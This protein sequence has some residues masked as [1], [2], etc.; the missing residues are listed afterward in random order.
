MLSTMLF[1]TFAA[2]IFAAQNY[3]QWTT[4][5]GVTTILSPNSL[6]IQFTPPGGS[7]ISSNVAQSAGTFCIS[8]QP[9]QV[10]GVVLSMRLTAGV[11]SHSQEV[12][13]IFYT[14]LLSQREVQ[15]NVWP[16]PN[17]NLITNN[18]ITVPNSISAY[19][20]LNWQEG[21]NV[22][23]YIDGT[24]EATASLA[25]FT[26]PLKP[27]IFTWGDQTSA[28]VLALSG[29]YTAGASAI[30]TY[31]ITNTY[32]SAIQEVGPTSLSLSPTAVPT[33]TTVPSNAPSA[34]PSSQPSFKPSKSPFVSTTT[35][36]YTQTIFSTNSQAPTGLTVSSN[37]DSGKNSN[38]GIIVGATVGLIVFM[39][40]AGY[41]VYHYYRMESKQYDH[42]SS[43]GIDEKVSFGVYPY[44]SDIEGQNNRYR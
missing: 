25:T 1:S 44:R 21:S 30:T 29:P 5:Y 20:C 19:Y 23:L 43:K 33:F 2:Q 39:L 40:I 27:Q 22:N 18:V 14:N 32:L 9:P 26:E 7:M 38:A 36:S 35:P 24:L 41:G 13:L 8:V 34:A 31:S 28:G 17:T 12:E 11:G 16:N 10:S 42:T 37:S 15:F 6:N 3:N 4:N